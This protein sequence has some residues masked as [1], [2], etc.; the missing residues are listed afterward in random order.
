MAHIRKQRGWEIPEREATPEEVFMNR[1]RFMVAMGGLSAAGLVAG[2]GHERVFEPFEQP[3]TL[4]QG[5]AAAAPPAAEGPAAVAPVDVAS[6]YPAAQNP[7]YTLDRPLT[8]EQ[9]AAGYNNF[10]EFSLGKRD[11][12]QNA[13]KFTTM[14][15]QVEV[16]G[17][18][19]TVE[20]G[21]LVQNPKVFDVD[22][23][24]RKFGL[25]ERLYRH[26]CVEAWAMA[27]PWTGFPMVA[28]LDEVKPLSTAKFVRMT[29]FLNPGEAPGQFNNPQWP[30]P[31]VEALTIEEAANELTMLVTGIYGKP[32]PKQHGAPIRL[33]IPW[34]YGFKSIKSIVRVE[35][36][37]D[38]PATFWNS[39]VPQEYG[40]TA[41]VEPQVPHPRWSQASE[42]MIGT[43]PPEIRR[44]T[45]IYNGY[46][47]VVEK[48]YVG[49]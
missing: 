48:L 13:G 25:E 8:D 6:L 22:D 29:T 37:A 47:G 33:V 14:P 20:V 46:G 32:L 3:E 45:N 5:G 38:K 18:E 11:V 17:V 36:T 42:R 35:F 26:R 28:F 7:R 10:Y 24:I 16:A 39:L 21:G 31:Y 41:N 15:W 23:L 34:K 19:G 4:P 30:W 1:R 9:V 12:L 27:V 40:F 49:S 44:Q 2:C 43:G